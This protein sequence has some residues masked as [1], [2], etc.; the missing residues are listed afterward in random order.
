MEEQHD[1]K[2]RRVNGPDFTSFGLPD[3]APP[4]L[5][6]VVYP[7]KILSSPQCGHLSVL[8]PSNMFIIFP[9]AYE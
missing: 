2:S 6:H 3:T 1:T 9:K 7:G 5:E 4:Q 8:R